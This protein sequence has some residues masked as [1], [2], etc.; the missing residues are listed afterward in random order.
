M[1]SEIEEITAYK[2]R[3]V[4]FETLDEARYYE[5]KGEIKKL[6][7]ER[8]YTFKSTNDFYEFFEGNFFLFDE[9]INLF[10]KNKRYLYGDDWKDCI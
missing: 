7:K 8:S 4:V 10:C 1:C 3:G 9:M 6:L 5:M 2:S